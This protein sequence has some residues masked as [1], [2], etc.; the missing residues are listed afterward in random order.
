[1]FNRLLPDEEFCPPAPNPEDII[2]DGDQ[3]EGAAFEAT[4]QEDIDQCDPQEDQPTANPEQ[5][6]TTESVSQE[7]DTKPDVLSPSTEE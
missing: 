5:A 4:S 1:M 3:A 6:E 7:T 2:Y